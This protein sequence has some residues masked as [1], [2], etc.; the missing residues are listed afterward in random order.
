MTPHIA[1]LQMYLRPETKAAHDR[2]W[3]AIRAALGQGD[4]SLSHPDDLEAVWSDPALLLSQ[5]CGLPYRA[6]LKDRVQ[7]V[8]TPDYAIEGCAPGFYCSVLLVRKDDPRSTACDFVGTRFARN[9]VQSQ[10]GW[11]APQAYLQSLD[12]DLSF[13][14]NIV[15]TGAHAASAQAVAEG[16]ADIASL[17]AVTWRL[18]QRYDPCAAELREIARTEPTP[19][20]PYITSLSSDAAKLRAAIAQAISQLTAEDRETLMLKAITSIPRE[21]YVAEPIPPEVFSV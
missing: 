9:M 6:F 5:T 16:R 11:A 18:C 10:S 21:R 2:Y 19:G 14:G 7:L 15:E 3:S 20:L 13:A 17:D 8:G 4:E 12:A 1:A